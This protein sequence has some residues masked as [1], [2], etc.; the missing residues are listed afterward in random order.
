M[1]EETRSVDMPVEERQPDPVEAGRE[2]DQSVPKGDGAAGDGGATAEAAALREEL[3]VAREQ[4]LRAHAEM[5]NVRRRAEN[6]VEKARKFAL[7]RFVRELLP[8]IDSL[9]KAVEAMAGAGSGG[10]EQVGVW[11]EGVEMT[12]SLCLAA[13][14]K[15][16]VEV[17]NPLGQPFSPDFHEAMSLVPNGELP[18]NT[19]MAVLQKGYTLNG[20]LIR[21][22]MV[23]VSRAA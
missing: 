9:E 13:V 7:E 1:S 15:F 4:V 20:R 8:V 11:R 10:A 18:P 23:I 14:G 17:L 2:G 3:A 6:D 22:A 16:D 19:V 12:L 5:Q 21:P